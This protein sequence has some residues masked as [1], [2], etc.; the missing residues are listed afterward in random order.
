L[1]D[2]HFIIRLRAWDDLCLLMLTFLSTFFI[3]IEVGTLISVGVSLLLVLKHTTATR[4]TLLG[5]TTVLDQ[6]TGL[7]KHK[8]KNLREGS[9]VERI[10]GCLLVKLEESMFFGNCGQLKD[11]LKRIEVFGDLGIHPSEKP[12]N[13]VTDQYLD[14]QSSSR[15]IVES[16]LKS[17]I[18]EMSAVASIDGSATQTFLELVESFHSRQISVCFVKLRE[19]CC[20][21]FDLAGIT[22]MSLFFPKISDALSHINIGHQSWALSWGNVDS[23]A[24]D[25][26]SLGGK[27]PFRCLPVTQY[28]ETADPASDSDVEY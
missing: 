4:L 24:T 21:N 14:S 27:P 8:F 16:H 7:P 5:K 12:I 17:I 15:V 18:F 11:R 28:T 3:G 22:K 25:N 20:V 23:P 2:V 26:S 9:Q 6:S 19:S 10:E 1:E 13:R